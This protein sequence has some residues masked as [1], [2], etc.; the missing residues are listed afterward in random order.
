V[1]SSTGEYRSRLSLLAGSQLQGVPPTL[2]VRVAC[3]NTHP[4][5]GPLLAYSICHTPHS[6]V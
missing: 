5:T 6:V 2:Q 3:G 4:H 1:G